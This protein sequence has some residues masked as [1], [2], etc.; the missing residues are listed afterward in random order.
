MD[1]YCIKELLK[2]VSE[3]GYTQGVHGSYNSYDNH[4]MLREEREKLNGATNIRQH[5]LRFNIKSTWEEQEVAGFTRD[6]SLG[7]AEAPGFRA[8]TSHAFK[9]YSFIQKKALGIT[10]EPLLLMDV[11]LTEK[12]YLGL[13][14]TEQ[15][16][17]KA[18]PIFDACEKYGG[19]F[20][21]LFHNPIVLDAQVKAFYEEIISW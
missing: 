16:L 1:D 21:V 19:H 10:V 12:K 3:N 7:F 4:Q 14:S 11:S 8:G 18:R 2:K 5:F 9:P 17:V 6:W 15:M 20:N 13:S